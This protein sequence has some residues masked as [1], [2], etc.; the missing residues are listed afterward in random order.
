[1]RKGRLEIPLEF[2]GSPEVAGLD[3]TI[4]GRGGPPATDEIASSYGEAER[5]LGR[6]H[7]RTLTRG[8]PRLLYSSPSLDLIAS[9][10]VARSDKGGATR[11]TVHHCLAEETL[12][13]WRPMSV[14]VLG[15]A[16]QWPVLGPEPTSRRVV[17]SPPRVG[18]WRKRVSPMPVRALTV[19]RAERPTRK[20]A[21]M[22]A[23]MGG[24]PPS[25]QGGLANDG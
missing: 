2:V 4:S 13:G 20:P 22:R 7:R 15:C 16:D 5:L 18:E 11:R 24:G 19:E 14:E 12:L 10:P 25:H 17:G 1:M 6:P 9:R 8:Q 3:L 23:A 21:A